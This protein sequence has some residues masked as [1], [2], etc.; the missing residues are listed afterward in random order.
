MNF[1][2]R[3][4]VTEFFQ[5]VS[6]S[7]FWAFLWLSVV[8][9]NLYSKYESQLILKIYTISLSKL[10]SMYSICF[11]CLSLCSFNLVLFLF[12]FHLYI[13][14]QWI[15]NVIKWFMYVIYVALYQ[16]AIQTKL[17]IN[18]CFIWTGIPIPLMNDWTVKAELAN[19]D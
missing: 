1:S 5:C 13:W 6:C 3:I 18:N 7:K 10:E 11:H 14:P 9:V 19:C 4:F 16:V 17:I 12:L 15:P 2:S 8:T